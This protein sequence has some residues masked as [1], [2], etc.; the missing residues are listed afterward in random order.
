M[1]DEKALAP[2]EV[3]RV[4][5]ANPGP[6]TLSGTNTW[7]AGRDPC[8]V[9]DPGPALPEHVE[10]VAAEAARRGGAAGIALTHDH[11]D[12]AE[13]ALELRD[14]LGGPPLAAARGHE[15]EL[16]DG[17]RFGPLAVL[18]TPGHAVDHLAFGFADT[19]FTGDAVL[20]EGSVFVAP[21]PGAMA[22]YLEGLRRLKARAPR[23]ICPGHG[24]VVRDPDTKIDGYIE[25]RLE[26]EQ[27][28]A[29]AIAAGRRTVAEL[30]ETVW[31]D[32]PETLRPVAA[33][34]LAAHLDKLA[35]EGRLPAGVERPAF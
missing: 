1:S 30:L 25:H 22:G 2:L 21:G 26:R 35:E 29:D 14:R 9:I 7:L 34:T 28:L 23:L 4:R 17:D 10:A 3:A 20:G 32:V 31:D 18:A 16:A 27:R 11:P 33:V 6:L 8:W 5:A 19:W 12:H 13:G 15:V 24:P